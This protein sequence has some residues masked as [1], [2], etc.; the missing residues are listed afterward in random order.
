MLTS[1][2]YIEVLGT[3]RIDDRDSAF[4]QAVQLPGGGILC[5]FNVG[6]GPGVEGGCDSARSTDGGETWTVEGTILPSTS[7]PRTTNALKLSASPDGSTVYAYGARYYPEP[8]QGFADRRNDAVICTSYDCG[9][10]WSDARVVPMR[11]DCLLEVAHGALALSSGQLLAPAPTHRAIDRLGVEVLVAISDDGGI[12]WPMH[13]LSFHDPEG[14]YGYHEQ[15]LAEIAPG[16][17]MAVSWTSNLDHSTDYEDSFAISNDGGL[18]WGPTASTG[19]MGQTMTPVSLG[20]DRLLVLYNRRYGDQGI[21]MLL[22]TFTDRAWRVECDGLMYDAG[23][24]RER[25][26]GSGVDEMEAFRFGFPTATRLHDGTFLAT[27]WSVE[28]GRCGIRWTKLR[29]DW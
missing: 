16:R 19:I 11:A 27:H 10:T 14:R 21:V 20:G 24:R 8:G 28:D 3:G 22:V 17:V 25:R 5:S 6:G 26:T 4:P 18:T 23:A 7:N 1:V 2:P 12:T 15:K 29:V 9:R 13:S